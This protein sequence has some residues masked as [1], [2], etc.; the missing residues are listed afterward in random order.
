MNSRMNNVLL[1]LVGAALLGCAS[2]PPADRLAFTDGLI[3]EYQ[4]DSRAKPQLQYYLLHT[5]RLVRSINEGDK[6]IARGRLISDNGLW[7]QEIVIPRGTPGVAVGSGQDWLAVSF[8]PGTYL[9]F[10]SRGQNYDWL[11]DTDRA[12]SGRYYLYASDWRGEFG[13]IRIGEVDFQAIDDSHI[14][15]LLVDKRALYSEQSDRRVLGGRR[16]YPDDFEGR[17]NY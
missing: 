14:A 9:Y 3:S 16:L 10:I 15:H 2:A 5:I 4:L 11:W 12:A 1:I 13:T 8:S 7:Y 17:Y 6:G